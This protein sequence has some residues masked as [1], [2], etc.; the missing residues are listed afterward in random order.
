MNR[1][2]LLELLERAQAKPCRAV[3]AE[4]TRT[5][6]VVTEDFADTPSRFVADI[7]WV[8]SE[9]LGSGPVTRARAE[10]VAALFTSIAALLEDGRRQDLVAVLELAMVSDS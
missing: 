9:T 6:C 8:P 2:E 5:W 4:S 10:L 3:F 1:K 7:V